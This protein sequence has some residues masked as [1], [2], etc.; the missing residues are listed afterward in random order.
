MQVE[1]CSSSTD[2]CKEDCFYKVPLVFQISSLSCMSSIA[3]SHFSK[4]KVLW[5]GWRDQRHGW[6]V[7]EHSIHYHIPNQRDLL[8]PN[9]WLHQHCGCVISPRSQCSTS[10]LIFL[11]NIMKCNLSKH[12]LEKWDFSQSSQLKLTRLI[13]HVLDNEGNISYSTYGQDARERQKQ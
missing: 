10:T 1:R 4:Q 13:Q 2:I 11:L 12:W 3:L 5:R 8:S 7:Q 6:G 9:W